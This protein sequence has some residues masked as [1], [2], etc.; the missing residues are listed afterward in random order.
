MPGTIPIPTPATPA[1]SA[2]EPTR[3][4]P[5]PAPA[6]EPSD[7]HTCQADHAEIYRDFRSLEERVNARTAPREPTTATPAQA[8]GASVVRNVVIA[9]AVLA[10]FIVAAIVIRRSPKLSGKLLDLRERLMRHA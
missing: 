1:T 3:E 7:G 9:L 6:P 4:T 5:S 2:T 8:R 10:A